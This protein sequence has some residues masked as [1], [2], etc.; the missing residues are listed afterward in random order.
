M[1]GNGRH[2]SI[3]H[4]A[5][6]S[7]VAPT[8]VQLSGID[9]PV[10]PAYNRIAATLRDRILAG[11]LAPHDALPSERRLSEE[12]GVSRMTAR[13]ALTL[14]ER[15]GHVY[16]RP[17]RGSFVAEPRI[18]VR[19]GGFSDEVR[20]AGHV[21]GATLLHTERMGATTLA[22]GALGL[23]LG[24][25][26]LVTHRLRSVDGAPFALEMSTWPAVRFPDL[27]EHVGD[28]S[29]WAL[30]RERYAVTPAE[31]DAHIEAVPLEEASAR[32]LRVPRGAP[33]LLLTRRTFDT[34]GRCF[35]LARDLY[36]G[37]RSEFRLRLG[38]EALDGPRLIAAR[39]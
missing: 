18:G 12:A 33:G 13:A 6:G 8:S 22:A 16:R 29:L 20:R 15:E 17:A 31:T 32:Q 4:H 30:L 19:P 35:E 25:P 24:A 3:S 1:A 14:L 2:T 7:E 34:D 10:V 36:R 21:P 23:A 37:D 38:V 5:P 39:A 26:V 27:L 28:G 11:E 9:Q